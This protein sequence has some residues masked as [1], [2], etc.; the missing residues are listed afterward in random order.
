MQLQA[1]FFFLLSSSP[2]SAASSGS[3]FSILSD[4]FAEEVETDVPTCLMVNVVLGG[5]VVVALVDGDAEL[6][7]VFFSFSNCSA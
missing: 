1:R 7:E 2:V 6:A 4:E 5:A 3:A